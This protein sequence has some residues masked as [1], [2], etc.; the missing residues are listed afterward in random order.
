VP[1]AGQV[2]LARAALSGTAVPTLTLQLAI[3]LV[4]AAAVTWLLLRGA[5]AALA[6]E[7]LLFRGPDVAGSL[8]ARPAPRSRP[9]P[10][11]GFAAAL[12]AFAG[13]WY[14]QGIAPADL[15]LAVPIQQAALVLPLIAVAVWQRVDTATPSG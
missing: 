3:S 14:A 6:D 15:G 13:L 8:F 12:V 2:A 9:T 4:A 5:A 7:E 1:F 11:Q 10:M